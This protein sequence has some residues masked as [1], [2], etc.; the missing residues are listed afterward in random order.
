MRTTIVIGELYSEKIK[1]ENKP[2]LLLFTINT[3]N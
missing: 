2:A 1:K 3:K